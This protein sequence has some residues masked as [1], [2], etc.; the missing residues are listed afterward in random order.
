GVSN[1]N[2][3]RQLHNYVTGTGYHNGKSGDYRSYHQRLFTKRE[4][5]RTEGCHFLFLLMVKPSPINP[6]PSIMNRI[7]NQI[8]SMVI[9]PP[10]MTNIKIKSVYNKNMGMIERV[11]VRYTFT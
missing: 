7:I 9:S 4:V 1:V 2:D 8:F 11:Q 6:K 3:R 10:T 5:T